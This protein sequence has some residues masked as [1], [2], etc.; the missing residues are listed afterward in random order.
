MEELI[1]LDLGSTIGL[2]LFISPFMGKFIYE[3]YIYMSSYEKDVMESCWDF[4]DSVVVGFFTLFWP[5]TSVVMLISVLI[6][7]AFYL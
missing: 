6:K 3:C 7:K 5:V 2:Y 4:G 1:G